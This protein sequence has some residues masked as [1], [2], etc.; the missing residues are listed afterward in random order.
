MRGH[1]RLFFF[2]CSMKPGR[3]NPRVPLRV[4]LWTIGGLLVVG[5]LAVRVWFHWYF[6]EAG[7]IEMFEL[8]RF[9]F[10]AYG[11]GMLLLSAPFAVASPD[12]FEDKEARRFGCLLWLIGAAVLSYLVLDSLP[13]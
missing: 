1:K 6:P 3:W 2:Y 4:A 11:A 13:P 12:V 8:A 9:Q 10:Y 7:R 5:G